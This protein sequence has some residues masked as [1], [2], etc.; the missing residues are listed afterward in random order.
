L[1]AIIFICISS[2]IIGRPARAYF[3]AQICRVSVPFFGDI[4]IRFP[5][6]LNSL[7]FDLVEMVL[8]SSSSSMESPSRAADMKGFSFS[9]LYISSR[10][11]RFA[12]GKGDLETSATLAT[13]SKSVRRKAY[14]SLLNF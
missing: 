1:D 11:W 14:L 4:D 9:S 10:A 12:I 6:I 13:T 5:L 3:L 7:T 2:A 8:E